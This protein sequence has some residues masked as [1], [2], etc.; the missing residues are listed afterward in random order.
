MRLFTSL[1]RP[2]VRRMV[3]GIVLYIAA[4]SASTSQIWVLGKIIDDGLIARNGTTFAVWL[5]IASALVV[6]QPILWTLGMRNFTTS[7][8]AAKADT[9]RLVT[10]HLNHAGAGTRGAVSSGEMVNLATED[11]DHTGQ[12]LDHAGFFIN[13]FAMF[14]IGSALVW[15]IHPLLGVVIVAGSLATALIT[16]PLLGRF[17]RRQSDYRAMIGDLAMQATDIVGGLRVLRG[18]GGDLRFAERYRERSEE[19]RRNGYRVAVSSSW[20]HALKQSLPIVFVAA[21]AWVGALLTANGSITFGGLAAAFS[22]ATVFIA[23]SGNFINTASTLVRDWVSAKRIVRFLGIEPDIN[24]GGERHGAEGELYDPDSN[25][26]VAPNAL[27]VLVTDENAP[28]L[29]ACERLARHCDSEAR[30]GATPLAEIDLGEIRQ[31]VMLLTDEDY[32]FAQTLSD[33]LRV[34]AAAAHTAIE[35]ACAADVLSSLG[36]LEAEVADGGRNLSGG[37][38][39]RLRLARAIAAQRET[40]LMVEPTSA[41]DAHT[42]SIVAERVAAARAGRTTLV[43]TSSPLWERHADRVLRMEDGKVRA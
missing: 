5:A 41:V 34:D 4:A 32:L 26:A 11:A 30:W 18:I 1:A 3:F 20:I 25:L 33:T 10:D 22:F 38:R 17:Q 9:V 7:A 42:E 23:V 21:I 14:C 35:T 37:Q 16:G 28:A 39:Q 43:V 15:A 40:L 6:L 2:H 13:T 31:R 27:T 8:A 19:L 36:S 24:T 12:A 29:A